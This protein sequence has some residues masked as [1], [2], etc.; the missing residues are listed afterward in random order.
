MKF[1]KRE[2]VP[3]VFYD[4][5]YEGAEMSHPSHWT[6]H[7]EQA[8]RDALWNIEPGDVIL[9]IGA[10]YG[11]YSLSALARGAARIWAW[12]PQGL[13]GEI[14]Q[15]QI[16]SESL[17]M[18][19]WSDKV[20]IYGD[21]GLFSREGWLN[22]EDQTFYGMEPEP[23]SDIIRVSTLDA[24]GKLNQPEKVDWMKLDVEGA[25][26]D[27]M[28]GG[29]SFVRYYRPKVLV[30]N[31]NFKRATIEQEIRNF[32]LAMNYREVQTLPHHQVTHSLYVPND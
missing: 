28:R 1:D 8:V 7:D 19:D 14:S 3:G 21:H 32:L 15:E 30:E 16:F 25:E 6:H 10:A 18:N 29:A 26:T 5:A 27:I 20:T 24:W 13:P 22:C 23:H 11:S 17:T 9:D 31:H 12:S 2:T 4:F